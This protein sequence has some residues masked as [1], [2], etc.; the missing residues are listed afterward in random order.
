MANSPSTAPAALPSERA[1]A[2]R[3]STP[4]ARHLSVAPKDAQARLEPTLPGR[5]RAFAQTCGDQPALRQKRRGL[6]EEVSWSDYY[7]RVS[8][9]AR[10]LAEHG[11]GPGDH[12]AILSDNRPEW[13]YADLAAQALGARSVGIYATSPA[14][15]VAM[16]LQHS[17]S[18]VLFCE[19]QEQVDKFMEVAGELPSLQQVVVFEPRGTRGY[20]DA[21]LTPWSEFLAGGEALMRDDGAFMTRCIAELDPDA[22]A[23]VVYTSGTT[24]RPKGAMIS[25]RNACEM[26]DSFATLFEFG[27]QEQVLSYLP[28]CHVAEKIYSVLLPLTEGVV[29]HF[30]ESIDTV[31][32]DLREVSPTVFLGVPRIWEKI[33]AAVTIKLKNASWLKRTLSAFFLRKGQEIQARRRRSEATMLDRVM[34]ALGDLLIYRALQ[35]RLGLRRCWLPG[36]G[37]APIAP[38]LLEW[39]RCFGVEI[40]EGYGM[41]ELAGVSHINPL[42]GNRVGTVGVRIPALE[43]R[44]AEDGEILLRGPA[45]FVG[46]LHDEAATRD[47]IDDEGWLHT[48]DIGCIE[49]GY[50]TITG[51]KKEI[52]ITAGGK[53]LSPERIENAIKTSPYIKEVVAIGDRR[54]FV[55]ALVQIEYDTVGYWAQARDIQYTSYQDLAGKDAVVALVHEEI[56]RG[57][58]GLARVEQ[59]RSFRILPR[60]LQQDDGELTPTQKVRRGAINERYGSLIE[61]I[62]TSA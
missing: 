27:P 50:L 7:A 54:K 53:N 2:P 55:A 40:C 26:I 61:S 16:L 46:Y 43:Q 32:E 25:S 48:G 59:V 33:H 3:R 41:T 35:D 57:N 17:E 24:G 56:A 62:Y 38:E 8:A 14:S 10:V 29:V 42:D 47:T 49:D 30:G 1:E 4:P 44:I 36:R 28:L 11:I 52:L 6:W 19:D 13:L 58:D 34:W 39:Y 37:A 51:R 15:D 21:R 31:Q 12:V 60:Q 23:M 45:V 20:P 22:P 18:K 9:T 5:L